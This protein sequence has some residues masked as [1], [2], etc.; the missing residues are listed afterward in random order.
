MRKFYLSAKALTQLI[1][2]LAFNLL[3]F[4]SSGQQLKISDFVLFGSASVT[5]SPGANVNGGAIG[6]YSFIK[7]W[8]PQ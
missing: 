2:F 7:T 4:N 5:M 1:L 8:V 3:A 6:S